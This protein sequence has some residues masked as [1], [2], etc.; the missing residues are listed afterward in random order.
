MDSLFST[1]ATMHIPLAERMRPR[2]LEEFV[3][4]EHLLGKNGLLK[5]LI[6]NDR[7][8]SVILWGPPGTGKTT[9][10]RIIA[11]ITKAHFT[12]FSAVTSGVAD[13]RRVVK[14]ATDRR[15]FE[16][17]QTILFVDEIHR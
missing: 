10:A 1:G 15:T 9:I 3:G 6:E 5:N 16:G 13:I 8:S 14:E 7:L 12:E 17:R 11:G 4:Q 2:T